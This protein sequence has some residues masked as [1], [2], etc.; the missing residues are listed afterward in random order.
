MEPA[1]AE[2]VECFHR[3]DPQTATGG[4]TGRWL[5]TVAG[6]IIP[7]DAQGDCFQHAMQTFLP[8]GAHNSLRLLA[9]EYARLL[10][11]PFA[12][13]TPRTTDKKSDFLDV[14]QPFFREVAARLCEQHFLK[15]VH[16]Q[17]AALGGRHDY[18]AGGSAQRGGRAGL[19]RSG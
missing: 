1:A 8:A 14:G 10:S 16:P 4:G 19:P 15:F 12:L 7:N 17:V 3:T 2:S 11:C 18:L 5:K 13:A 9:S 6:S